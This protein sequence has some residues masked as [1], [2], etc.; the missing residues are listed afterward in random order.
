MEVETNANS[1][2]TF[3]ERLLDEKLALDDKVLKLSGFIDSEKF[4]T[5]SQYQRDLLVTQLGAMKLYANILF[6]RIQDLAPENL[7][8]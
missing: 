5:V 2:P 6:E 7:K 4:V 1:V 3:F 8:A